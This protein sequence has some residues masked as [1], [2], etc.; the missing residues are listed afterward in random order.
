MSAA[1]RDEEAQPTRQLPAHNPA[2]SN[3]TQTQTPDLG[4]AI[5]VNLTQRELQLLAE[6]A[7]RQNTT[8]S[9]YLRF[10]LL[11]DLDP[12]TEEQ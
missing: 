12:S 5:P 10:L 2:M 8:A 3:N 7:V 11:R 9:A 1:N 4:V 6:T